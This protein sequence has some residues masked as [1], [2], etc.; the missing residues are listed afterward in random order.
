[1]RASI[2][3]LV[4]LLCVVTVGQ[5]QLPQPSPTLT[6]GTGNTWNLDWEGIPGRTYFLQQSDDLVNWQFFPTIEVG[7]GYPI[8]YG[9]TSTGEKCF[10]RLLY[11]DDTSTDSY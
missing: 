11:T 9:F 5:A 10:V 8:P 7:Y 1:M 3:S 2:L 4:V 6:E